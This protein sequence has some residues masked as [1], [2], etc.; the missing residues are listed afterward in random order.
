MKIGILTLFY[1]NYNYGGQLQAYA[2]YKYLSFLGHEVEHIA[3][4]RYPHNFA[5][6]WL[7][8]IKRNY[9]IIFYPKEIKRIKLES[10]KQRKNKQK[11]QDILNEI[12]SIEVTT[13]DKFQSFMKNIPH[14]QVVD[15]RTIRKFSDRYDLVILGG[16]QIWNPQF[17]SSAYFGNWVSDKRRVCT[18]SVSGGKDNYSEKEA[19]K[20][21]LASKNIKNISVREE[22][23]YKILSKY[24]ERKNIELSLDPVFLLDEIHWNNVQKKCEI[25][26]PYIFTYLLNRDENSRNEIEKFAKKKDMQIVTIPHARGEYNECDEKFG[27]IKLY[28][29]GPEEF[30]GLISN[31][32]LVITDSFHGTCFSIIYK[33][34][35]FSI[36]NG[37]DSQSITTNARLFTLLNSLDLNDRLITDRDISQLLDC[38]EVEYFKV[39]AKKQRRVQ[40]SKVWLTKVLEAG[41]E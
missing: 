20:I 19:K 39:D 29:V 21:C 6:K 38:A 35:F 7:D 15:R 31:A 36:I 10:E 11:Y 3:Y 37:V 24:D 23:L 9:S 8:R 32:Q 26:K 4:D 18:Y 40:Q 1:Q 16:D 17:F 28:D 2:L 34:Q 33:K 25:E 41:L 14:T 5:D 12:E 30:L 13:V 22:N 27:D